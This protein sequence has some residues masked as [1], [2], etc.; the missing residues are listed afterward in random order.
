MSFFAFNDGLSDMS[1][2]FFVVSKFHRVIATTLGKWPQIRG[3]AKHL[4]ERHFGWDYLEIQGTA[5]FNLFNPAT[6]RI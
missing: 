5:I 4:R 6:T 1:W 3:I 2:H